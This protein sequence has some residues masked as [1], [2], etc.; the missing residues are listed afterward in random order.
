M[1]RAQ[2]G[3]VPTGQQFLHQRSPG[4]AE[5]QALEAAA[6]LQ[7][8]HRLEQH[9]VGA[10][11]LG[12]DLGGGLAGM[13]GAE[14]AQEGAVD[15]GVELRAVG[16]GDQDAVAPA[17][18]DR[19]D[20]GRVEAVAH[21]DLAAVA[22]FT[23]LADQVA[24]GHRLHRDHHQL[25]LKLQGGGDRDLEVVVGQLHPLNRYRRQTTSGEHL[26]E[27]QR[28]G[29]AVGVVLGVEHRHALDLGVAPQGLG[30][31][32]RCDHRALGRDA[33]DEGADLGDALGGVGGG[34]HRHTAALGDRVC[35]EGLLGEGGADQG[36]GPLLD[37]QVEG[38]DGGGL[39][40]AAVLQLQPQGPAGRIARWQGE[41]FRP[42]PGQI[43]AQSLVLAV[44]VGVARQ[45]DHGPDREDAIGG[46]HR[47]QWH[48]RRIGLLARD[49]QGS[50]GCREQSGEPE[51]SALAAPQTRGR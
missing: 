18:T 9:L 13:A 1:D 42:P 5:A 6:P 3:V 14:A 15:R 4:L 46:A 32:E 29:G 17:L 45:G 48:G 44:E 31:R 43:D 28:F 30:D 50:G 41:G 34:H 19:I 21:H 12:G 16:L 38:G 33:A 25:G 24:A 35:G 7:P 37:Q 22:E 47:G 36:Q 27:D 51:S 39:I 20:V 10:P 40:A 23:Q 26:L 2:G 8:L 11:G 49:R